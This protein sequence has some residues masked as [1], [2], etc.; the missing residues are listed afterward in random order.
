MHLQFHYHQLGPHN[1][2]DTSHVFRRDEKKEKDSRNLLGRL[3]LLLSLQLSIDLT[4]L[5]QRVQDVQN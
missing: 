4:L 2:G 3:A 1:L 5:Y